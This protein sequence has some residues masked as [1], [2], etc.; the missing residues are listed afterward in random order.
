MA[1]KFPHQPSRRASVGRHDLRELHE[2][3]RAS[4]TQEEADEVWDQIRMAA[5]EGE[6]PEGEY[7]EL[8]SERRGGA[9]MK[10]PS[11]SRAA[12]VGALPPVYRPP[13]MPSRG[14]GYI[15]PPPQR[16]Q[17]PSRA[18]GVGAQPPRRYSDDPAFFEA[19]EEREFD[20]RNQAKHSALAKVCASC[21]YRNMAGAQWCAECGEKLYN[22]PRIGELALVGAFKKSTKKKS[23]AKKKAAPK[24]KAPVKKKSSAKKRPAAKKAAPKKKPAKKKKVAVASKKK[25]SPKKKAAA[26]RKPAKKKSAAKRPTVKKRK[27][28]KKKR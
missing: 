27:V 3:L 24:K 11:Y 5:I 25:T 4:R 17:L 20:A 9:A 14:R 2:Q 18:S 22:A 19:E 12:G 1:Y 7:R 23:A 6:I 16:H 15:P 26:K 21:K 8:L 28:V 13:S 10:A